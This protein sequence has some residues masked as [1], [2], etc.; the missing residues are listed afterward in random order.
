MVLDIAI[1]AVLYLYCL[2]EIRAARG[3]TEN[4]VGG[5]ARSTQRA[6]GRL[7]A[8]RGYIAAPRSRSSSDLAMPDEHLVLPHV[9]DRG[10][11]I[12]LPAD[13]A[14]PIGEFA[15]PGAPNAVRNRSTQR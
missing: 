13:W 12:V 14:A 1:V 5:R 2:S 11:P 7:D 4:L 15:A 8:L 9:G 3:G 10:R 6:A